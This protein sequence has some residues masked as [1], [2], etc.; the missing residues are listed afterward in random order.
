M[1]DEVLIGLTSIFVLGLGAQ[2]LACIL[3]LPA[4][5]F[6]LVFG[7]IA[8]PVSGFLR[9]DDLFGE[10]ERWRRA[11][12]SPLYVQVV[13]P[14]DARMEVPEEIYIEPKKTGWE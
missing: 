10:V 12:T 8:G 9:P 2:V 7:L 1:S 14:T 11:L 6:L 5:L 13:D 3:R 4:I